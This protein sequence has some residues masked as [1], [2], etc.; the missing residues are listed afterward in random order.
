M[1]PFGKVSDYGLYS[2]LVCSSPVSNR[3]NPFLSKRSKGRFGRAKVQP[4]AQR[5][6]LA[7]RRRDPAAFVPHRPN[8]PGHSRVCG[9][10]NPIPEGEL[11]PGG[12][13]RCGLRL[14][15]GKHPPPPPP[16]PAP[17]KD[18]WLRS[19]WLPVE[20]TSKEHD[21]L[22]SLLK[23]WFSPWLP[24][25]LPKKRGSLNKLRVL[26]MGFPTKQP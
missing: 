22:V 6:R 16:P 15:I 13:K 4:G 1:F 17:E 19:L 7:L 9:S 14:Q 25:K 5:Q 23:Q 11:R 8:P 24:L 26:H 12:F 18:W 2:I 20:T 3:S 21:L 10:R